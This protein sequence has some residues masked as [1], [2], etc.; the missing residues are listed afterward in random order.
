M[1]I[2]SELRILPPVF[3][4]EDAK[5]ILAIYYKAPLKALSALEGRG[6]LMRLR[7]NQYAFVH[8]FDP[9]QA[10]NLVHSP[11]Y[12]S[13][14]TALSFYGLIPERTEV[15]LS[16]VDGRPQTAHTP[17]GDFEYIS[18]S[19]NLFALG[20]DLRINNGNSLAIASPEKALLDT[21]ARA[22]LKTVT[23]TP[24]QILE[25][26]VEGLRVD[27]DDVAKL[28]LKRMRRMAPLYRNLA[29]RKLVNARAQKDGFH[30]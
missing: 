19:R 14:E 9:L 5:S 8:D 21:L 18:Q 27:R 25:Y 10:A 17:A 12:V 29:P 30:E 7:R 4:A 11:S 22:K 15:V 2:I 26:V 16:V 28:S 20:M 3:S 1:D 6:L 23:S 24:A 13:F